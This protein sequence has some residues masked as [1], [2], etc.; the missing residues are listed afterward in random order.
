MEHR[1]DRHLGTPITLQVHHEIVERMAP[2]HTHD[3]QGQSSIAHQQAGYRH[4]VQSTLPVSSHIL[5][6]P[7]ESI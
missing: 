2:E 6:P 5:A 7:G 4:A 3:H 1:I